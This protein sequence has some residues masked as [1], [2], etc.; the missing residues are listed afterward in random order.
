MPDIVQTHRLQLQSIISG[1]VLHGPFRASWLVV[2]M[3]SLFMGSAKHNASAADINL[4]LNLTSVNDCVTVGVHNAST[5]PVSVNRVW[6]QLNGS[7]Y[8]RSVAAPFSVGQEQNFDFRVAMPQLPGSYPLTAVIQY[9]NGRELFSLKHVAMFHNRTDAPLGN[10]GKLRDTSLAKEGDIVVT[11][12]EPDAWCLILPEEITIR[13]TTVQKNEKRFHVAT[14]HPRFRNSYPIF[15]VA[16]RE[17]NGLHYATIRPAKLRTGE[18]SN[19]D[20]KRGRLPNSILIALMLS[21]GFFAVRFL[22]KDTPLSPWHRALTKFA[23]RVFFFAMIY[24]LL[25]NAPTWLETIADQ[26][27]SRWSDAVLLGLARHFRSSNYDYFFRYALDL[28]FLVA[29][30]ISPPYLYWFDRETPVRNDAYASFLMSLLSLVRFWKTR[31]VHWNYQSRLGLLTLMVKAFYIPYLTSWVI[32]NTIHQQILSAAFHWNFEQINIYLVAFF[33]SIDTIIYAFGYMFEARFLK[34][35]IKSVE[36]TIL[37]WLVCIWCYPP[38]NSF[39]FSIFDYP[40]VNISHTWPNWVHAIGTILISL[41]WGVFTWASIALGFK[42]SNLTNRGIVD[43]GPYRFV[44]H[45][46]YAAK[47]IVWYIEGFIL[48]RYFL[49]ILLG[50]TLIYVL[51]AWTEERHLSKDPDYMAYCRKVPRR[52][53]PGLF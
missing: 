17:Q 25:K 4:T 33:I 52:F 38:F 18:P 2:F 26:F 20:S 22:Y 53:I 42:A 21:A 41:L 19:D 32:N 49:G 44:R 6:I 11:S 31:R 51:R 45:P 24:Y 36:P 10:D 14:K 39:S 5:S 35:E 29:A 43:H 34:N 28:Y 8:D 13:G 23:V 15:A 48:G 16:E 9:S 30:C 27:S 12:D 46:A 50:F 3:V 37:G 47:L 7:N 1:S 40:I